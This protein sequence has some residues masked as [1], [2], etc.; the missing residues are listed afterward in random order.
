MVDPIQLTT[1]PAQVQKTVIARLEDALADARRGKLV[2]VAIAGFTQ[3]GEV[4]TNW[5]ETD[6]FGRLLGAV[7]RLAYR[8]ND[9][10]EITLV[11]DEDDG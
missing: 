10:Q 8:I 6:D 5:S 11:E 1:R 3:T 7:A 4:W 2:T 9:T